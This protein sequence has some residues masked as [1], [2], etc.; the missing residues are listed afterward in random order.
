MTHPL[1]APF[2]LSVPLLLRLLPG[3]YLGSSL[4][5]SVSKMSMSSSF[6]SPALRPALR[7]ADR[8]GADISVF[9]PEKNLSPSQNPG[10]S[11]GTLTLSR[12]RPCGRNDRRKSAAFMRLPLFPGV[13]DA[14]NGLSR[15]RWLRVEALSA[16]R[17][18][19]VSGVKYA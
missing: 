16:E 18:T 12:C 11:S 14:G 6:P 3:S 5:C 8:A 1:R 2:P 13:S 10:E 17:L 7:S 19:G 9:L 15:S 4:S